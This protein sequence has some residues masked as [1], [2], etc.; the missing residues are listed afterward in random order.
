MGETSEDRI[1]KQDKKVTLGGWLE[2]ILWF[3]ILFTVEVLV[4]IERKR[5]EN[6][7]FSFW[8]ILSF[9]IETG[10][11]S[12][13]LIWNRTMLN[14]L[15]STPVVFAIVLVLAYIKEMLD[16][17]WLPVYLRNTGFDPLDILYSIGGAVFYGVCSVFFRIIS[18]ETAHVAGNIFSTTGRTAGM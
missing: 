15:I 17:G 18:S 8:Y 5:I 11:L 6:P 3:F 16:A 10:L 13:W 14:S 12:S 2:F 7:H 9:S 4:Y 1:W